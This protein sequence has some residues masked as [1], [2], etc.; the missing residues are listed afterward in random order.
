MHLTP[1]ENERLLVFSAAELAR[2]RIRNGMILNYPEAIAILC[3]EL[4]EQAVVGN[5]RLADVIS[6]GTQILSQEDVLPGVRELIPIV[7]V[8]GMFSDGSKLITIH[9]P[10]RHPTRA[11]ICDQS[12][13]TIS[14]FK[15]QRIPTI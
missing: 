7:Q 5:K 8:E 2:R 11:E 15:K 12:Y 4:M 10:I 13:L 1:R 9:D 6:F 3:D 14:E